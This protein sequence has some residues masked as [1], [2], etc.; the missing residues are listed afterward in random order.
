MVR[1]APVSIGMDMGGGGDGY[2]SIM[3]YFFQGFTASV[4]CTVALQAGGGLLVAYIVQHT[5][6]VVKCF[7][8]A[9]AT[10]AAV[11]VEQVVGGHE[12]SVMLSVGC[13]MVVGATV[14]YSALMAGEV[15]KRETGEMKKE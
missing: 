2:G 14:G 3:G 1:D 13:V 4:W 9:L 15:R 7:L 8:G 5:D 12:S 10:V 11:L 6:N